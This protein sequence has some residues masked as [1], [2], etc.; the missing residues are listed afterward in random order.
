MKTETPGRESAASSVSVAMCTYNGARFLQLQLESV[1]AQSRQPDELVVCDDGSKDETLRLLQVFSERAK[2]PVR[3]FESAGPRLG[4]TKNFERAIGL[5]EGEFICLADQDD[6]W[7]P[8]KLA[9]LC[10]ALET[11]A[12]AGYVF[13]DARLIAEHGAPL[14]KNLWEAVGF[15]EPA[16]S[17]F[18]KTNQV[19]ALL[20]RASATGATMAFRSSLRKV[21]LPIS[22]H[23]VQD[24]WISLLASCV[25]WRGIPVAEPL[26]QYRQHAGQQI[27]ALRMT[28]LQKVK[29]ARQLGPAEYSRRIQGFQDLRERLL[30]AAA[31]GW[32][33]S[34]DDTALIEEKIRH[35]SQRAVAHSARGAT[36]VSNVISEVMTGRYGRFSNSWRSVVEDLC[37]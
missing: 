20:H 24:Y 30:L 36:R 1:A 4:S 13:S 15:R 8:Q 10:S 11:H 19:A 14:G 22:L 5:C 32:V 18:S 26:I 27:G 35:C 37:F 31:E 21:L 9:L 12:E 17:N 2:F 16:L 23:F 34:A 28:I 33:C 29:W 25:G 6:I 3:I 7:E